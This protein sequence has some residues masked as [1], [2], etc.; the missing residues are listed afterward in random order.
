MYN[1]N[2]FQNRLDLDRV[3]SAL[4]AANFSASN[5]I[6]TGTYK[7]GESWGPEGVLY[8]AESSWALMDAYRYTNDKFFIDAVRSILNRIRQTQKISG[9]WSIDLREN[10]LCFKITEEERND[11]MLHEDPPTTSAF[12]RTIAEYEELTG[13]QE[14]HDVG[15]KAFNYLLPMWDADQ[16][17]FVDTKKRKLLGLR[18][19]P[20][21]Y[22]LFFLVGMSAWRKYEPEEIDKIYPVLLNFVQNNFSGFTEDTMPLICALHAAELLNHSSQEFIVNVMKPKIENNLAK[23]KIF[24]ISNLKGAYGHRDGSR[25]IV[26]TEAHLR[27]GAGIALAMKR[28]DLITNTNTFRNTIEYVELAEWIDQ[29]R[30]PNFFYEYELVEDRRKYG[31]GSP[32]QYLPFWWIFGK[33]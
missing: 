2:D 12:L 15:V 27:S 14:F 33:M 4:I 19:N 21:G 13:D 6:E 1:S 3:Q 20:S 26:T 31:F 23:N 9:G 25:G 16:G 24:K 5:F 22:H 18:S 10:G 11:S 17:T 7:K 28:Y 29:M 30:G 8:L 32:G